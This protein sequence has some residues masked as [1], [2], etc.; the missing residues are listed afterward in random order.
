MSVKRFFRQ[1]RFPIRSGDRILSPFETRAITSDVLGG[2]EYA[3]LHRQ[4]IPGTADGAVFL[5]AVTT[6]I[7]GITA[8]VN[9][10]M[11]ALG[12]PG[13]PEVSFAPTAPSFTQWRAALV[14][15]KG[16]AF[17]EE[18]LLTLR[19][20]CGVTEHQLRLL[21]TEAVAKYRC[22]CVKLFG[23]YAVAMGVCCLLLRTS[24]P[25]CDRTG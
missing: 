13:E 22:V 21:I 3:F 19:N 5:K 4:T 6:C 1:S 17:V 18:A 12:I 15:D 16:E 7:D 8:A 10:Y 9:K 23:V 24:P 2:A 11:L 20:T 14:A 25:V